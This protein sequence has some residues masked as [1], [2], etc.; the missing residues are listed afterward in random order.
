MRPQGKSIPK[1][2]RDRIAHLLRTTEVE[3]PAL[4]RRFGCSRA[5]VSTINRELNIRRYEDNRNHFK[6]SGAA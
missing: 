6:V 2:T 4:A 1:E 3:M 5:F